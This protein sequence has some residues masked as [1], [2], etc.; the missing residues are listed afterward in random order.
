MTQR[1]LPKRS[2]L[3]K[4][5]LAISFAM[6]TSIDV[7]AYFRRIGYRGS[8][9]ATLE[10]LQAI[11]LGHTTAIAYENLNPLLGRPVRLDSISLQKKLIH[12]G[13]GGYCF[14]H[15]LLFS[16]VLRAL[17]FS[18]TGLAARV[19]WERPEDIITG[20][21]HM[22]IRVEIENRFY[23][24]DA[25][26]GGSTPTGP[27][28]FEPE[29]EQS[30]PHEPFRLIEFGQGFK[31]QCKI[32]REW[33]TLYRFDL[34]EAFPP[35]YEIANYYLSTHPDSF[36]LNCLL[37]ARAATNCR[38]VLYNDQFGVHHLNGTTERR[39]LKDPK[40]MREMLETNFLLNLSEI[41]DLDIALN[42]ILAISAPPNT[43]RESER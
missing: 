26:F 14:E 42:R 35:D 39:V 28:R 19:L 22:L 41:P 8:R 30:T 25:G 15:N 20:R 18:V 12:D 37:V 24:V 17:G 27:L 21:G 33:K 38:Y 10:T 13:R 36:F 2:P 5:D 7:D 11:H 9:A 23:L 3:R 32:A 34:Q 16:H 31:V 29:L 6:T 1:R 40:E 4:D 43:D